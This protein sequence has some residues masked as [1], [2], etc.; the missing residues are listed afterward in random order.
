MGDLSTSARC[1]AHR[2]N[3]QAR[4]RTQ[5]PSAASALIPPCRRR[6][7]AGAPC[8]A[9]GWSPGRCSC[10]GRHRGRGAGL[11]W[12]PRTA[13]DR[14]PAGGR[15]HGRRGRTATAARLGARSTSTQR[16][17]GR[18]QP[19]GQG[20]SGARLCAEQHEQHG[21]R[22]Q[23]ADVQGRREFP[24]GDL[25]QH[26]TPAW[27]LKTLYVDND[28]GNTLTPHQP[29]HRAARE[30]RSRSR[31]R[32]TCTSRPDGRYAIVVAER[33]QRLDFRNPTTMKLVHSLYIPQCDGVD[34]AD[35]SPNGRYMFASCEFNGR[36]VEVDLPTQ[37]VIRTLVLHGGDCQPPGRQAVARTGRRS[38]PPISWPA[39][40]G[41]STPARSG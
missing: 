19:H 8:A 9:A 22:H 13:H 2:A 27:N 15:R 32:T 39:A 7:R 25:P 23:P 12:R 31:I 4:D 24:T 10:R 41:R 28:L 34:H 40:C 17:A 30:R 1:P 3:F 35:F 21:R 29:P 5:H 33:L 20:R 26:V 6:G 37:R 38:T 36:M 18:S 16:H 11:R 14:L